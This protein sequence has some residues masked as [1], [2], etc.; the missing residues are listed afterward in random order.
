MRRHI[1]IMFGHWLGLVLMAGSLIFFG[2]AVLSTNRA[3]ATGADNFDDNSRDVTKWGD[4]IIVHGKCA[5]NEV[6]G[7]LEY[8][9]QSASNWDEVHRPWILTELPYN[10]DWEM[11]IDITNETQLTM[12]DQ[13]TG[14][15][16][17]IISPYTYENAIYADFYA[18]TY[19]GLPAIKGFWAELD[20]PSDY[21]GTGTGSL[22]V[23]VGA[24]RLVFNSATKVVSVY[25]DSDPSN[26]YQW[27]EYASFGVGGSGGYDGTANWGL[28]ETDKFL[29]FVYGY[30]EITNI[31]SGQLYGDNFQETGGVVPPPPDP[32]E[33]TIGTEI[34][35]NGSSFGTKKGKALIG[36]VAAKVLTWAD[37]TI[38]CMVTKVPLPAGVYAVTIS[39]QP[40]KTHPRL[41]L[42]PGFAVKNPEI[43]LVSPGNGV[44]DTEVT[45]TGSFVSTKKGKVY[46]E[47]LDKGQTKKKSCKVTYWYMNPTDGASEI[48][49]IVPKLNS[50]DYTLKV[51]N[52]VGTAQTT[53]T[54][55]PLP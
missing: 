14:F 18:S 28:A 51:T 33:G 1:G 7:R 23:T 27:I 10:A 36:S 26:G 16:I 9:C 34:T 47:Y 41:I 35:I 37:G 17:G 12:N 2:Q 44:P 21:F 22:G 49:F 42:N 32:P 48:R 40:Y 38:T 8:T 19:G 45:I 31:A 5:L 39:P 20:T 13:W 43:V 52:K 6:N 53:F 24:I 54:V 15:G 30:S 11:Q 3:F 50:G 25:Y 55:D 46:L 4:D 29:P